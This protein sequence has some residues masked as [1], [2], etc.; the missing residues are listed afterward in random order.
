MESSMK[1]FLRRS[2]GEIGSKAAEA[3]VPKSDKNQL[4]EN[5]S[6]NFV[7]SQMLNAALYACKPEEFKV[8]PGEGFSKVWNFKNTGVH[9]WPKGV[10]FEHTEGDNFM[11]SNDFD[12][13]FEVQPDGICEI[14][15]QF[16][17]PNEPGSYISYFSLAIEGQRFGQKVW[18]SLVVEPLAEE[19]EKKSLLNEDA[20]RGDAHKP[21]EN[22][23]EGLPEQLDAPD[24][25]E[26]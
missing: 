22:A 25:G 8:A 17:A 2:E 15:T 18:V 20:K 6:A 24:K 9:V 16:K 1:E 4:Q 14:E 5:Q 13:A 19:E 3:N 7:M 11:T 23:D 12:G 21:A 10:K 26:G